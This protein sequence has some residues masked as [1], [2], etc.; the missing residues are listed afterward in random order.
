MWGRFKGFTV[1]NGKLTAFLI[2][3]GMTVVGFVIGHQQA[4]IRMS[5]EY[6]TIDQYVR[7]YERLEQKLDTLIALYIQENGKR[8]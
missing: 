7:D 6:V 8:P 1:K 3:I 4:Q 2:G 5:H